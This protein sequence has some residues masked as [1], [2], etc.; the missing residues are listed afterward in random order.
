MLSR[1]SISKI[2]LSILTGDRATTALA[3]GKEIGLYKNKNN[4]RIVNYNNLEIYHLDLIFPKK[5][6]PRNPSIDMKW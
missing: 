1:M 4:T 3:I 6:L 2:K 5:F